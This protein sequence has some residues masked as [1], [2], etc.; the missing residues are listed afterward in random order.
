MRNESVK[1]MATGSCTKRQV[2]SMM[3]TPYACI[4]K[5]RE[6]PTKKQLR[7]IAMLIWLMSGMDSSAIVIL[8]FSS[9]VENSWSISLRKM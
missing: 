3:G 1:K 9:S 4:P 8:A 7:P 2:R 5:A 6:H